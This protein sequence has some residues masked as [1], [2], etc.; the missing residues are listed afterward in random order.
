MAA[1]AKS[2]KTPGGNVSSTSQ[3]P[4]SR[5][6]LVWKVGLKLAGHMSLMECSLCEKLNLWVQAMGRAL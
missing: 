6:L 2:D 5:N 3:G 1:I 4:V